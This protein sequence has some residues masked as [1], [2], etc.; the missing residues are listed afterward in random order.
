MISTPGV[1]VSTTGF[2]SDHFSKR[3]SSTPDTLSEARQLDNLTVIDEQV[4]G[5]SLVLDVI[6][7]DWKPYS[8]KFRLGYYDV[9]H[10]LWG[11]RLRT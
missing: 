1:P 6:R 2:K 11:R 5:S 3:F 7:E 10:Y 9:R 4:R 8:A